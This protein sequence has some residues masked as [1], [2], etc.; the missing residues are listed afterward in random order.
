M[1]VQMAN[2]AR[3]RGCHGCVW[4]DGSV[5]VRGEEQPYGSCQVDAPR[6]SGSSRWPVVMAHKW[7]S[8]W[9]PASR[10]VG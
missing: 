8:H 3:R 5:D 7:C 6:T 2:E 10:V 9:L 1:D 4:Y